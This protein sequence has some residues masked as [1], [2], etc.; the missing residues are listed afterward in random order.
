MIPGI[1]TAVL[2]VLFIAVC[3]WAFSPG[4]KRDFDAAARLPFSDEPGTRGDA[5]VDDN[6]PTE[7]T[8]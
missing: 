3:V 7:K 6:K 4:R 2:L 5:P 8:R 1:A